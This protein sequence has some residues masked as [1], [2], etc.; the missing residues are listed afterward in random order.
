MPWQEPSLAFFLCAV[1]AQL[2]EVGILL[3]DTNKWKLQP[4][5]L[6][7]V[8]KEIYFFENAGKMK[9]ELG[10]YLHGSPP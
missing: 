3:L 10:E 7:F 2:I 1:S 9:L 6:S 4:K 5:S 8:E